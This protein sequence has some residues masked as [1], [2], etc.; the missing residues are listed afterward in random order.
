MTKK[1]YKELYT[2]LKDLQ[3]SSDPEIAHS[4]ADSV[5][6]EIALDTEL[7]LRQKKSLVA[8]YESIEKWY[9]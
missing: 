3:A 6:V 7:T 4:I 9:S 5:L 8:L 1:R 2:K